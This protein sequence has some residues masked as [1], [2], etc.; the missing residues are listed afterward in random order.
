M[1]YVIPTPPFVLGGT[2]RGSGQNRDYALRDAAPNDLE[3]FQAARAYL[4]FPED[5]GVDLRRNLVE[6]LAAIG[7]QLERGTSVVGLMGSL[8]E[9]RDFIT[10]HLLPVPN[11]FGSLILLSMCA[12][13][14]RNSPSYEARQ[15]SLSV[16]PAQLLEGVVTMLRSMRC[17]VIFWP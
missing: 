2:E 3:G 11:S 15:S 5:S 1:W 17:A 16:S 6:I 8:D 7:Q 4:D 9:V 12:C 14:S 13:F 10:S